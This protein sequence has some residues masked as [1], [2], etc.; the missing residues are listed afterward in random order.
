MGCLIFMVVMYHIG[1]P[2]TMDLAG[3]YG[4]SAYHFNIYLKPTFWVIYRGMPCRQL[5]GLFTSV[6]EVG[7][8]WKMFWT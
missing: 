7:F 8:C 6:W 2:P 3:Y 1:I 5:S 4:L